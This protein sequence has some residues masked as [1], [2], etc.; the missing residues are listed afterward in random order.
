MAMMVCGKGRRCAERYRTEEDD[1]GKSGLDA[2]HGFGSCVVLAGRAGDWN[3]VS[4]Q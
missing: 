2:E 1:G 3:F 4:L